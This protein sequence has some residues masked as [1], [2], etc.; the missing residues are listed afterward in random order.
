MQYTIHNIMTHFN[1]LLW[2]PE[3]I[4]TTVIDWVQSKG[5]KTSIDRFIYIYILYLYSA[6]YGDYTDK[7]LK[8]AK[9]RWSWGKD[10]ANLILK[11]DSSAW[12]KESWADAVQ[13]G[14]I[15]VEEEKLQE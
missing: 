7:N 6:L 15:T 13:Q 2:V 1:Y 4:L 3:T 14:K 8:E 12:D 11:I 10:D 9:D 5:N